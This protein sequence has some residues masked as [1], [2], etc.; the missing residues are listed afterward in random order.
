MA[1]VPLPGANG[2]TSV[3]ARL[4]QVWADVGVGASSA[5]VTKAATPTTNLMEEFTRCLPAHGVFGIPSALPVGVNAAALRT[6]RAGDAKPNVKIPDR[7]VNA[8]LRWAR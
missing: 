3:M 7:L 1:S 8:M 4:G 6:P 5:T 2:T